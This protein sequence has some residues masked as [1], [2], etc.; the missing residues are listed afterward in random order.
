MLIVFSAVSGTY[1]LLRRASQ[2]Q[3][4]SEAATFRTGL[5]AKF[6][7]KTAHDRSR[8]VQPEAV[9]LGTWQE[10]PEEIFC[11]SDAG[12]CVLESNYD[13]PALPLCRDS[14][15]LPS[16]RGHGPLAVFGEV[17]EDLNESVPV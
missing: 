1:R 9:G 14:K 12:S 15:L 6:A 10:R 2:R 11:C 16:R 4:H 17:Q 3:Y 7:P 13:R 5:V 8:N